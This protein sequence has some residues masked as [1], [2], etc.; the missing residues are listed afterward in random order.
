[1]GRALVC[2]VALLLGQ[3]ALAAD[4]GKPASG[5]ASALAQAWRL[6]PQAAA[7]DA[8]DAE[9]Q[10]AREIAGGLTPEPGAISIGSRN[11]RW[12]RDRG[13][14]EYEVELATP[15]W[16]PGQRAAREDAA[17]SQVDEVAAKRIAL[18][19]ELAGELREAW[20][21]LAAARNVRALAARRA[22]TARALESDV[23]R[24]YRAGDL[25]RI[26]GNL[27]QSE[28]LAAEAEL[29]EAEANRL[30]AEQVLRTLTGASAPVEIGEEAPAPM[31]VQPADA[32]ATHP[33]LAAAAAASRS[34]RARTTVAA[35]SRRAAPE[36]ALR[37]VR[38]R[39]DF[40]E[41]YANSIGVRL[42]IPFSSGALVRRDTAAA[43]AEASQA[44][45]EMLR[46]R[47]R[48]ELETER[49][50]RALAA[51]G[52]QLAMAEE[53]RALAADNLRLAEKAFA[54]GESDLSALLR[55][56]AAAFDAESFYDRQR[57]ARAAAISRLNQ[58]LGAL[59]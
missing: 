47:T 25:S 46:A 22:E 43:Q 35:E 31:A 13:Q 30:Q 16:L 52:R 38:E 39:G 34:A 10:A 44:D 29:I 28:V 41:P 23:R 57:V 55:I 32:A 42:K 26:D 50:Q 53:R 6:H 11:D 27:A 33:L 4:A 8:R 2:A 15:L 24:R 7:L 58:A 48:V 1:M 54:L 12:N 45:A 40:A 51:A 49:A 9:A 14:Q 21:A 17:M 36:L 5:L 18:R 56:R 20:W 37:A 19:W 3:A 59:P